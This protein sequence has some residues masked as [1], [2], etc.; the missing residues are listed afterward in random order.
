MAKKPKR[1]FLTAILLLTLLSFSIS[2]TLMPNVKATEITPQQKGLT[3]LSDV[4]GL[5]L[6]EYTATLQEYPSDLYL[7]VIPQENI[8]YRLESTTSKLDMLYTFTN[9]KLR[10]IQVLESE[11]TQYMTKVLIQ[12]GV[13]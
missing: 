4:V 10:M 7:N 11:G 12:L 2:L 1:K 6:T 3:I 13:L 9:G 5:D 8:R